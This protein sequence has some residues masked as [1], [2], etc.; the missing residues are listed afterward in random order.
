MSVCCP[1]ARKQSKGG[2]NQR[3]P[4]PAQTRRVPLRR[5]CV[6]RGFI[7]P[8]CLIFNRAAH[9]AR[10]PPDGVVCRSRVR[11]VGPPRHGGPTGAEGA[12]RQDR[13]QTA[14]RQQTR[15]QL[16]PSTRPRQAS[17]A[18]RVHTRVQSLLFPRKARLSVVPRRH[19]RRWSH[20]SRP[21]A[22]SPRRAHR[23]RPP[24]GHGIPSSNQTAPGLSHLSPA[25]RVWSSPLLGRRQPTDTDRGQPARWARAVGGT[26]A[27]APG[28]RNGTWM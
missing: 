10:T 16:C 23:W 13:A 2:P 5:A 1:R 25:A 8:R 28:P 20:S 7:R 3:Q 21:S 17:P 6:T 11:V 4:H 14:Q 15:V 27:A 24:G 22:S 19:R 18:P 9:H 26:A 12:A